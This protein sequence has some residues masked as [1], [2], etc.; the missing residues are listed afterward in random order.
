MGELRRAFRSSIGYLSAQ[1]LEAVMAA[2]D[3]AERCHAGQMRE[4]GEPYVSHPLTTALYLAQLEAGRDTLMAALLHDVIEDGGATDAEVMAQFGSVVASLVQGVTKIEKTRFEGDPSFRQV[5]SL[6]KLLLVAAEDVRVLVIK[7]ADRL[8]NVE[9]LASLRPDKQERIARETLEIYVP[10]A[11][12]LGLWEW[13]RRMEERCFPLAYQEESA[14]WRMAIAERRVALADERNRFVAQFNEVTEKRVEPALVPMTDYELFQRLYR[15]PA[16]LAQ[17]SQIDSVEVII[18]HAA[19]PLDCY[20]VVGEIHTRYPVRSLSFRDFINAPQPS[21]YRALH[22]TVFLAKDH[23]LRLRILTEEMAMFSSRRKLTD[24]TEQ[25]DSDIRIALSSLSQ[26]GFDRHRYMTDL[27]DT[28]LDRM[29]VFTTGGE[30]LSLPRGATGVDFAFS[31]NPDYLSSLAGIRVNGEL[32]EAIHELKDGDTVELSLLDAPQSGTDMRVMWMEKMKSA[33]ARTSLQQELKKLSADDQRAAGYDLLKYEAQKR[34]LPLWWI[35]SSAKMQRRLAAGLGIERFDQVLTRVG[36]GEL[37]VRTV[38]EKYR[39]LLEM[40]GML[41]WIL[42]FFR[43]LPHSR[44]QDKEAMIMKID[45]LANDVPGM[46]Y[47]V[48]K[49]FAERRINIADFKVYAVPPDS[50]LYHIRCEA[51]SFDEFSDLFD[52]LGQVPNVKRVLRKK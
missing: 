23:E 28:V 43:L 36:S 25:R 37:G 20:R 33:E 3:A 44:V 21:G 39:E 32:Y 16:R 52:A 40:P 17:S 45:V 1:D 4:S 8:H 26:T 14:R 13:K 2:L 35:S 11:R 47:N 51:K 6:R 38:I 12:T 10:F 5:A 18:R 7:I 46:I 31:V 42:R 15:D 9:T 50:A 19:S 29:N 24:W 34:R 22:T 30:I 49:C 41:L 27:K 48:S